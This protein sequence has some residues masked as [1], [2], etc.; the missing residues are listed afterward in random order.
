MVSTSDYPQSARSAHGSG[1]APTLSER[2]IRLFTSPREAF[3]MPWPRNL[4]I[5]PLLIM[6]GVSTTQSLLLRDIALEAQIDRLSA[7][8]ISQAQRDA[9]LDSIESRSTGNVGV[10]IQT[11]LGVLFSIGLWYLFPA[12]LY[13]VGLN[14]MLGA[15]LR[16]GDILGVTM[17]TAL[18][19]GLRELIRLPI[20][21]FN[22][23]LHVYTGPA[24]LADSQ[25][26]ALLALLQRFDLFDIY[27]IFLLTIGFAAISGL[28]AKRTAI[29]VLAVWV[30][31]GTI[32]VGVYLSPLREFM[33]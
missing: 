26:R 11:V 9:I 21:L 28:S 16:Y 6:L 31:A 17:L 8:D 1:P 20:M 14:F 33:P 23:T 15:K 19:H 3:A 22:N 27:R 10:L 32:M 13:M 18:L 25:H 5:L 30:L 12:L 29:P 7:M 2:V 4:W 24:A